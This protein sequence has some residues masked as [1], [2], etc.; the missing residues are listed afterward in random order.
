MD[1]LSAIVD[2]LKPQ[3]IAAKL[4]NGAGRWGVRYSEFGHPS[5]A[6]VLKGSC[7]LAPDGVPAR[8]LDAGDFVLFPA[9]PRFTLASDPK[10][11]PKHLE[12]VPS[13][14]Q[15]EEVF[16]GDL[17]REPSVSLLG[18]YFRFDPVN[19]SVLSGLLPRMLHLP[20]GHPSSVCVT[21]IVD[22]I[23]REALANRVGQSF[24]LGRLVEIMLVETLRS[25]PAELAATGLLAGLR[26]PR[27]AA[28]LLAFHT[29]PAHPWT[30]ATLA[31]EASMSRSSFA[32]HFA[33]VM[34][35]TPLRYLLQWR[36]AMARDLLGRGQMSVAE[37]ALAVGYESAS[38][39]SIAFSREMGRPPKTFME[40]SPGTSERIQG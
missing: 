27:L 21:P 19:A 17:T 25:A 20:A 39:F 13:G 3:V 14:Q 6:L 5:Y 11:R 34:G 40:K 23:K 30:L 10:V 9:T 8:M 26:I 24:V 29:Q 16:H 12:P 22:L 4:V 38:G 15:V 32:A 7:W 37:T 28:A 36:L 33:R 35:V 18:G 1:A 2:L 31:R